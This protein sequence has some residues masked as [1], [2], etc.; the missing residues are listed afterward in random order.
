MALEMC[1]YCNRDDITLYAWH[2]DVWCVD[3]IK[4][5]GKSLKMTGTIEEAPMGRPENPTYEQPWIIQIPFGDKYFET[6]LS[7]QTRIWPLIV[8]DWEEAWGKDG[9]KHSDL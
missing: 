1:E 8:K 6:W 9:E 2:G 7:M 3:C 4:T 5:R